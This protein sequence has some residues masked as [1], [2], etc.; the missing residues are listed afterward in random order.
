ML[1]KGVVWKVGND[2]DTDQIYPGKYLYETD[3][4]KIGQFA[5]AGLLPGFAQ[6]VKD[7]DVILV[8]GHNFGCGSSREHAAIAL[9]EVGIKAVVAQS[10][11]RIFFRNAI[12]L[13]LPVVEC[14]ELFEQA[15]N[16]DELII[17]IRAGILKNITKGQ[18]YPVGV[19]PPEVAEIMFDGGLIEYYR[20]KIADGE[21]KSS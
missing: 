14:V 20:R 19:L 9:R 18:E 17:D 12:N 13:G 7:K 21:G 11:G 8:A 2:V 10:F 3:P 5:M 4:K 6:Q 1:V 16:D 15:G